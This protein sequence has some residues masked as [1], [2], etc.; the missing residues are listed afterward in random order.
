M[1]LSLP[2]ACRPC[3]QSIWGPGSCRRL[4][5]TSAV[6]K[7][8]SLCVT[9]MIAGASAPPT[10]RSVIALRW[11]WKLWR[12]VYCKSEIP[13]MSPTKTLKSQVGVCFFYSMAVNGWLTAF[14]KKAATKK[15][16]DRKAMK[17]NQNY[18]LI[19]LMGR[20]QYTQ[21]QFPKQ[22]LTKTREQSS[23]PFLTEIAQIF[24]KVSSVKKQA[25][26]TF[27]P[28]TQSSQITE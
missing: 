25:D 1:F 22:N 23:H 10:S 15:I 5:A 17:R 28:F 26:R 18:P 20:Y 4:S 21:E 13:G 27:K 8:V 3:C 6:M 12:P 14:E 7:R 11:I 9:T 16:R 24:Q 19:G 2:Q